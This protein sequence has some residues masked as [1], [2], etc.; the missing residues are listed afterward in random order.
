MIFHF[1][2]SSVQCNEHCYKFCDDLSILELV[3][4]GGMLTDYDIKQHVPSDIGT[5]QKYLNPDLLQTQDNLN[6]IA[7]WTDSNLMKLN[8]KKLH[9]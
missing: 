8:E 7:R 2:P 5:D 9:I 1:D 4:I 3:A 6:R